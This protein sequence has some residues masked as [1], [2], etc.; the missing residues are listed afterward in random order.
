[1]FL[2]ISS[3]KNTEFPEVEVTPKPYWRIIV[4][5]RAQMKFSDF[6]TTKNGM[7]EPKCELFNI[8]RDNNKPVKYLRCDK[9]KSMESRIQDMPT[10]MVLIL[11]IC[12]CGTIKAYLAIYS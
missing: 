12:V 11:K 9:S 7:V 4:D 3:V 6:F 2:D 1:M 8:W 10:G 5:E